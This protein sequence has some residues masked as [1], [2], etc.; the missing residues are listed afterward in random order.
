V[1]GMDLIF[2]SNTEG[3]QNIVARKVAPINLNMFIPS[4]IVSE[5][6]KGFFWR[7]DYQDQG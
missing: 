3:E 1:A 6:S 4:S 7:P 2:G 5:S